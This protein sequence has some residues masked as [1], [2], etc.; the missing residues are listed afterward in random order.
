MKELDMLLATT[1]LLI[2]LEE[3]EKSIREEWWILP[4]MIE[5]QLGL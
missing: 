4:D 1:R 3:G 5:A 2:K